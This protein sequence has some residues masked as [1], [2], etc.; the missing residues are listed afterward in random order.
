MPFIEGCRLLDPRIVPINGHELLLY[1]GF[2][3]SDIEEVIN[4]QS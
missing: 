4:I 1:G 2:L 3:K